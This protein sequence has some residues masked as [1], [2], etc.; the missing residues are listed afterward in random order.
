M[1]SDVDDVYDIMLGPPGGQPF[2]N[3][4][5]SGVDVVLP[6]ERDLDDN[7]LLDDEVVLLAA[8]GQPLQSVS[9]SDQEVEADEAN[10]LLFY[11]FYDV[12][13]G[14]Y[15][16]AVR[17]AGKSYVVIPGLIVRR[18][19]AFV[20]GKPLSAERPSAAMEP[21]ASPPEPTPPADDELYSL[22]PNDVN[23]RDQD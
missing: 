18:E 23:Y 4:V 5:L 16:V 13:Y 20:N 8:D 19:G 10:R 22:P 14:V 3:L 7:P 1:G 17:I 12:P 15:D 9:S 21:P 11:R 6:I 2:N